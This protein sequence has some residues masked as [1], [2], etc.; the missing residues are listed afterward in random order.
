MYMKLIC[1]DSNEY[2]AIAKS[3]YIY[4]S[5]WFHE[6]NKKKVDQLKYILFKTSKY[7]LA[8]IAGVKEQVMKIPYSAP[9]SMFDV[10]GSVEIED[11]ESAIEELENFCMNNGISKIFF[12]LPPFFYDESFLSKLQNVLLRKNYV[13]QTCD[14]NYHF[15]LRSEEEFWNRLK[16]NAKNKLRNAMKYEYRLI[17]CDSLLEKKQAYDIISVNRKSKGYPL[18]MTWED[19]EVTSGNMDSDFFILQLDEINIASAIVFRVTDDVYQLIYWGDIPGYSG[20]NPMNYLAYKLYMFYAKK[21]IYAL[22][23][24]PASENS[25]PN[26]GLCTFKESLGCI[27]SSKYSYIKEL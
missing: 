1:A 20:M 5:V 9:F 3:A 12:R 21:G 10:Y 14:L 8:I 19:V 17:H 7:K 2:S 6:I 25:I 13:I 15:N 22:D 24:G 11:L 4:N 27:V 16:G 18:R 26:Y 23:I